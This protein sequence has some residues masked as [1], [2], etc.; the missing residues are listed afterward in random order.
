MDA[1][2]RQAGYV[3]RVV[4]N[5]RIGMQEGNLTYP[6][7]RIHLFPVSFIVMPLFCCKTRMFGGG[8][9]RLFPINRRSFSA[10]EHS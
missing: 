7:S 3:T 6:A 2:D 10:Y 5:E 4:V 9:I 8:M 1:Q